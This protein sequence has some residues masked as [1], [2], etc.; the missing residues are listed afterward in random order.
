MLF[1][2]CSILIYL[3]KVYTPKE[4]KVFINVFSY[5]VFTLLIY[6]LD[7]KDNYI[8]HMKSKNRFFLIELIFVSFV[9]IL[10]QFIPTLIFSI[11]LIDTT[12]LLYI[13]F[14]LKKYNKYF[15]NY[16]VF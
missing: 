5:L 12:F 14:D 6:F 2:I 3:Y 11:K 4:Y 9:Y 1:V 15:N 16:Q 10:S 7:I 13:H 8:S